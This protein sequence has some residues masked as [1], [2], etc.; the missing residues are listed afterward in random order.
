MSSRKSKEQWR[1]LCEGY[2]RSGLTVAAYASGVGVSPRTLNWWRGRF[3]L[4]CGKPGRKPA[5]APGSFVE[6]VA[7]PA[8]AEVLVTV[9]VGPLV[10]EGSTWP[11]ARWVAE[12]AA[13]C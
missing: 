4:R 6:V 2:A 12:L 1:A 13:Q 3:G 9:R 5:R 11:S 10:I 7:A 8:Q